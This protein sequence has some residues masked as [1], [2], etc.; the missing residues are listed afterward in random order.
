MGR[1]S[2]RRTTTIGGSESLRRAGTDLFRRSST[3]GSFGRSSTKHSIAFP[4]EPLTF[5]RVSRASHATAALF[6]WSTTVLLEACAPPPPEGLQNEEPADPQAEHPALV[7]VEPEVDEEETTP[8]SPV[9]P[10]ADDDEFVATPIIIRAAPRP[11][12]PAPP[13]SLPPRP[14]PKRDEPDRH[15]ELF[16]PFSMGNSRMIEEGEF[17]LQTVAATCCMRKRLRV[18]LEG[19]PA[20]IENDALAYARL[21]AVQEWFQN[22]GVDPSRTNIGNTP[23]FDTQD[24]PGVI[25]EL[26]LDEDRV[27]RDYYF[28][29]AEGMSPADAGTKDTLEIAKWL[30]DN[31]RLSKH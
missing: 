31:F 7:E 20:R 22:N 26:C 3:K 8:L 21:L 4:E 17:M 9:A 24:E 2:A 10:A 23:R 15:F 18:R 6:S 29:I 12:P 14:L 30:E 16:V 1:L 27:L 28:M 11:S 19:S 25:C 5:Q 13:S